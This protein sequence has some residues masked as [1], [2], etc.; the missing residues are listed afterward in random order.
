[1]PDPVVTYT[2]TTTEVARLLRAR[3]KDATTG[4]EIGDFN[5]NTRP[6][7][8]EV[9]DLIGDAAASIAARIGTTIPDEHAWLAQRTAAI[10]AAMLIELSY[11]P[12][13]TNGDDTAYAH[14]ADLYAESL[15]GLEAA[16]ED[17]EAGTVR[18]TS[19][20]VVSPT[21][22]ATGVVSTTEIIP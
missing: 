19:L 15:T 3:T 16:L 8:T 5:T 1:M 9:T 13:Q 11:F 18:A 12:E 17:N 22:T 2:P 7:A 20:P 14:L 21:M 4:T 6:T 10:R